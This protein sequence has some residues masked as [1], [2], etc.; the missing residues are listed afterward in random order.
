MSI[1]SF[2][3]KVSLRGSL[4]CTWINSAPSYLTK[5]HS[6]LEPKWLGLS[7]MRWQDYSQPTTIT[8]KCYD[9]NVYKRVHRHIRSNF[10]FKSNNLEVLSASLGAN[11]VINSSLPF[12]GSF[13]GLRSLGV[14]WIRGRR[15]FPR[16]R[17]RS[18]W[19]PSAWTPKFFGLR[20]ELLRLN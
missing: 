20:C 9:T 13:V 10:P 11:R 2:S 16:I 7:R 19:I 6:Q 1:R 18:S 14:W 8:E 5:K 17:A 12:P 3:N 15:Q 4:G